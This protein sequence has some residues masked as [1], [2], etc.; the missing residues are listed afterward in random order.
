MHRII[1]TQTGKGI[2]WRA[3]NKAVVTAQ[4]GM[5]VITWNPNSHR[6]LAC[7][8][9]NYKYTN[10]DHKY[11]KRNIMHIAILVTN[12][13]TSAF[14]A[15]HDRDPV[16]FTQLLAQ[17]R[18]NWQFSV[19]EVVQGQF[20]ETPS[21]FDGYMITGSPA[22]VNDPDPW[23]DRLQGFIRACFAEGAPQFGACYG[24]QVIAT[25]LGGKVA[26]AP[27][28]WRLGLYEGP[29][30]LAFQDAG[31][32]IRLYAC[33]VEQVT[34]LPEGAVVLG[35]T[36]DCPIGGYRIGDTVFCNQYHPEMPDAFFAALVEEIADKVGPE[37]SA[38]ARAS[39]AKAPADMRR[40]A[41]GLAAF[42]EQAQAKAAN[43]SIAVT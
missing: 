5:A 39:L 29:G 1:A 20:P 18:P 15:R 9:V 43:K 37:V 36:P 10:G 22:S 26:L 31:E 7:I 16:R 27:G 3:G 34:E 24:H 42:F 41:L 40:F 30:T 8:A 14:A 38:G 13:D 6:I 12:T 23:L 17:V 19:F 11:V 32:T 21:D 2:L 4:I 35:G 28:G 25:A 33:H